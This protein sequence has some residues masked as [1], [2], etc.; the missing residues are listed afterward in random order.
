MSRNYGKGLNNLET[1]GRVYCPVYVNGIQASPHWI[2][3]VTNTKEKYASY[4]DTITINDLIEWKE[5]V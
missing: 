1:I 5:R 2:Y 4:T 3:L